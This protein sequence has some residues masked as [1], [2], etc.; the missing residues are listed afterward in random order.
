LPCAVQSFTQ[1]NNI[2]GGKEYGIGELSSYL[3]NKFVQDSYGYIWVATD[4]GLNKYDGVRFTHYLNNQRVPSSLL[5]NNVKTLMVDRQGTLWVGCNNGLQYYNPEEDS[6]E[7]IVFPNGLSPHVSNII[8]RNNGEIWVTAAGWG[9]FSVNRKTKKAIFQNQITKLTDTFIAYFYED[10]HNNLWLGIDNK[11]LIKINQATNELSTYHYPEIPHNNINC[12][13]EDKA[14]ELYMSTSTSVSHYDRKTRKFITIELADHENLVVTNMVV[15]K[16]NIIFVSTNGKGLYFVDKQTN[17]LVQF[18]SRNYANFY[19]FTKISSLIEDKDQNLWLGCFQ[20]G[21]FMIP[22]EPMQFGFWGIPDKSNQ[23]A[24]IINSMCKDQ[25]GNMFC[26]TDGS[27][28]YKVEGK[29]KTVTH[30]NNTDDIVKV[31][32]DSHDRLWAGSYFRGLAQVDKNTGKLNFVKIP[33]NGYIKTMAQGKDNNLYLSV[34]SSG[35]IKYDIATGQWLK[36]DMKQKDS[37]KGKLDNDWVNSILCDSE[38]L[39]WLGHYKGVSCFDPKENRFIK[40]KHNDILADQIC[41]SLLAGRNGDIWIGTYNGLFRLNKRTGTI[42]RYTIEDGLSSNVICG[43]ALDKNGNVWCSTFK[44]INELKINENKIINYYIGNGLI[45]K[46]YNRWV[47]FQDKDGTIYFGGNSGITYFHPEK[48]SIPPIYHYEVL[49]TNAF[50]NNQPI[51]INTLSGKKHVIKSGIQH[52]K[53]FTFSFEDNTFT[54]EFSTMDFR[55][56]ENIYFEYRIKNQDKEWLS[57]IPGVNQITYHNMHPGKYTLE[58]RASKYG[59]YSKVKQIIIKISP[60]WYKSIWAYMAYILLVCGIGALIINLIRKKRNEMINESKL[61]FFINISHELRSPLTL[62]ISPLE[63]LL[64][65]KYDPSTMRTLQSMYRNT[66]RLL[67]LVNQIL[68]IRKIDKGLMKLKYSETEIVGFIEELHNVFEE[69]ALKRNIQFT[70]QHEMEKLTAFID[71][72]NF[73]KILINLLSNAFKYTP[74]GGEIT[75]SLATGANPESRSPLRNY[76][77]INIKDT[78]IGL[79]EDKIDKIFDR[80]YQGQNQEIFTTVGSGI[81]LNLT[82]LLVNLHYGTITAQNRK[83][84]KGSCF[85]V[86]IPLGKE[87]LR[88]ED[89]AEKVSQVR[90]VLHQNSFIQNVES[91]EKINKRKTSYKVLIVDDEEEIRNYLTQELEDIYKVITATNGF[92]ALQLA[93]V[94]QPDIIIS[95]VMMPQM[96]GITLVKKLKSNNNISHIPIILLTSKTEFKDRIDG[97]DKGADT[98]LTKP[99][100]LEELLTTIGNLIANRRILKGKFSGE[101]GQNDKIKSMD[102]KSSNDILMDRIMTAINENLNNTELNVELLAS[103]AGLSRVQ[104]HRKMKE[105]TGIST[106]DFIRNIRMKQAAVLLKEKGMDV[107]QVA[108]AVGF[109]N[110]TH[111]STVFKKFY[112]VSPTEYVSNNRNGENKGNYLDE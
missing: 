69:Q 2:Y 5:S 98:Y 34:F 70:F 3:F 26:S 38:G 101:Q 25:E 58:V 15:T 35:F 100:N 73:D 23:P 102:M 53:E 107:S 87:H 17:R 40:I 82:R 75:M 41:I 71:A 78:G 111:F 9:V 103:K 74:N 43:L 77:E 16:K 68:D 61:Q 56:P 94:Q 85:T 28:I 88:K 81:G 10:R 99:F 42:K 96:D 14:G 52:A 44:G 59:A 48:I 1:N 55:D 92:E 109:I 27:G 31:Y 39:I 47:N 57:T 45:D 6:F 54:L 4:Y 65:S 95:D 80:F 72:S 24:T 36:Y 108:Y 12:M 105:I 19:F 22:N 60:P 110:Q 13:V 64:Q 93:T 11:G 51:N 29:S 50:I 46:I 8:Q 84:T 90:P 21:I 89:F 63:K 79:E 32:V 112:G 66:N 83:D 76:I 67:G 49:T 106:I 91:K 62:L 20:K 18:A 97:L 33:F 30:F 37:G 104:L 7:T 86:R